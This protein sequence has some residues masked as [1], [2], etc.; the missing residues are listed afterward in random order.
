MKT[1][2]LGFDPKEVTSWSDA[3]EAPVLFRLDSRE[4]AVLRGKTEK[5]IVF[6]FQV[7]SD[8]ALVVKSTR[9]VVKPC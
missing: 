7:M 3:L 6:A 5:R 9:P 1:A 2:Y 4:K 8:G